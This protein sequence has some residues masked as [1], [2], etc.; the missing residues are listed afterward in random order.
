[1]VHVLE[2]TGI[3]DNLKS[4]LKNSNILFSFTRIR[5]RIRI[6]IKNSRNRSR[7]KTGRLRNPAFSPG[8]WD[9]AAGQIQQSRAAHP[10]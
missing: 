7:P 2:R 8:V 4:V 5:S 3:L 10:R 6:Q 1:M 9:S